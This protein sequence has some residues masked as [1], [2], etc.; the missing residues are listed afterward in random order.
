MKMYLILFFSLLFSA[1]GEDGNG[2]EVVLPSGL[3]VQVEQIPDSKK[4]SV[5]ASATNANFY[6]IYFG[7]KTGEAGIIA[8][9][10]KATYTYTSN[11]T[12]TITV[13]ANA[14]ADKFISETKQVVID[15]VTPT[16]PV[17][18]PG[19]TL[20][21]QDEFDGTA[22]NGDSWTY[23]IGTGSNGWGNNELQYYRQENTTVKDG[24]LTITAKEETFEGKSY[25]SSRIIT[26]D[27]KTF[28]YGRVDIR[29]TLPKGQGI[30]PAL[31]MLG[32]NISSV[33]WPACGEIDVME[34]IG[35]SGRE[36]TIHGTVHWQNASNAHAEYGKTKTLSSGTYADKFHVF[37]VVWNATS[38]KWYMDDVLYNEINIT[39]ADLSEFHEQFFVIFN[40]AVGGNWPKSPDT[41]T[42]FPQHLIVDYIRV[43]Q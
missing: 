42:T 12:Y 26:K 4:V 18:P 28:K 16:S 10:G 31:W 41:S 40:L 3:T 5:T 19:M 8:N 25:T 7:E 21:W 32:N 11:G 36:N 2:E 39:P 27:K 15:V 33:P 9:N 6:T 43:F 1:C 22:L 13:N 34:M 35:G 30:W 23:E 29:A 37:S 38:I 17:N 24:Y 14:T 20:V